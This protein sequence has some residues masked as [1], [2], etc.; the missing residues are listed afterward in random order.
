MRPSSPLGPLLSSLWSPILTQQAAAYIFY[1]PFNGSLVPLDERPGKEAT[2]LPPPTKDP[3]YTAP[4]G[5][6]Q[7]TPGTALRMRPHAYPTINIRF[8]QDTFQ[9][10]YRTTDTH[11]R[12]SWSV[13][14]VFIPTKHKNC[15]DALNG[16]MA[17]AA[18]RTDIWCAH[19]VVSYNVPTDS[20][21]PDAAPSY[22]LQRRD[23]YGEIRDLLQR[24]YFVSVPDYEGPLASFCAG[25]QSGHATLD[26]GRAVMAVAP[27][28][29]LRAMPGA[30][31]PRWAMWGYSGG[32]FAVEFAAELAGTY[33]PDF[34]IAGAVVGGP[35][36]NLTTANEE[37]NRGK[38]AGLIVAGILGIT[39]Q[40]PAAR[41]FVLD[42]LKPD[43]TRNGTT[44][45]A[46]E[47]M[48]GMQALI[49]FYGHNIPDYFIGGQTDLSNP[50]LTDLYKADALMGH[51]GVPNMPAFY[52]KAVHDE[53]TPVEETDALVAGFCKQGANILY[54]RNT[55]GGHND[56]LWSG[57]WRT[58]D[59]LASVLDG[60]T[61][62]TMPK[63][64]CLTQN[65][66]VPFDPL[67]LLP[68]WFWTEG[69]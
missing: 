23:P 45:M 30:K 12:P 21:D 34:P 6:E 39:K 32:S 22:L 10:L 5:W 14:T 65:V 69:L 48:T 53:M 7:T 40:Q 25:V 19:G 50:V 66:T 26:A 9:V 59:Y 57:R 38:T 1:N 4:A 35:T 58:Y 37:M 47:H 15:L 41:Q 20:A 2:Y 42:R 49:S 55:L 24:G 64:G 13:A 36:P 33:A 18:D 8:A 31:A 16:T 44:F 54:H 43:G 51:H 28:F 17:A 11:S 56:E 46:A 67:Y 68:D 62:M 3:W 27:Q 52:Y 60:A 63:T 29:G 61:N